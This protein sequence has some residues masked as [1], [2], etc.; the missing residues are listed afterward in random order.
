MADIFL[1]VCLA[2]SFLLFTLPTVSK[3]CTISK[4]DPAQFAKIDFS[5]LII[6]GGTAGLTLA[7]R[8]AEDPALQ[9]GVIE[10]GSFHSNDPIIDEP[11]NIGVAIGNPMYDWAFK[12]VP[13]VGLNGLE[14]GIPRGKMLGGSS[15]LNFLA[16][17][18]ASK[19][20]YDA[21][22][23][24]A[25]TPDWDWKGLL[26]YFKRST[27][28]M[29]DQINVFPGIPA[30]SEK[31]GSDHRLVGFGGPINSSYNE[32]YMD[33]VSPYVQ[34]LNR[35][36]IKTNANPDNGTTAGIVN[37]RLAIDRREGVRSYATQYYCR[38]AKHTNLHVLTGA[39]A[40]RISLSHSGLLATAERMVTA[41]GVEFSANSRT[42]F[43]H[44][45]R[46]VILSAGS[47]Q[48]P[49]ILELSGIGNATLLKAL[50]IHNHVDLPQVGEN[51]Q[52]HL[53]AGVQYELKP[54]V[55]TFDI[56]RNNVTFAAEQAAKYNQNRT[57]FLAAVDSTLGFLPFQLYLNSTQIKSTL[58]RFDSVTRHTPKDSLEHVQHAIQRS[59]IRDGNVPQVE[60]IL[61]TS[62]QFAPAP[63]TSYI[64]ILTGGLHPLARGSVHI[65]TKLPSEPP[66]IDPQYLTNNFD[67]STILDALKVVLQL[68]RLKPLSD[69]IQSRNIPAPQLHT[70]AEL[71]QFIRNSSQ[72][73]SHPLGTAAMAPR[74]LGGVVDSTLKVYGTTNLRVVDASIIPLHIGAHIQS[75]VYAIAEKAA[76]MIKGIGC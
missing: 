75:T 31:A 13:Q 73:S 1:I 53:F 60:V 44:A 43:A 52:D 59:W 32:I 2:F 33:P 47:I 22:A 29:R 8:L 3:T 15:G 18:R 72:T 69:I 28:T 36:G 74:E 10:A 34:T 5:Y 61:F 41:S 64:T 17:N 65:K 27:T 25:C 35:L 37:T 39:R 7:A 21:W 58:D 23:T 63:N 57:G 26:P 76:D 62:G 9:I 46:E 45:A 40:N 55:R 49:Q 66:V 24:F 48:T 30:G 38:L 68:E 54:R 50:N 71:I 16:W 51:H 19:P 6:G 56:L 70:D 11:A 42:Y 14:M 20:E 4:M 12:S 67:V